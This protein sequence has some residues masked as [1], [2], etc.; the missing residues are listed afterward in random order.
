[1]QRLTQRPARSQPRPFTAYGV[2]VLTFGAALVAATAGLGQQPARAEAKATISVDPTSLGFTAEAFPRHDCHLDFGGGP[3]ADQDVWVFKLPGDETETGTFVNVTA[4]F[5]DP[6]GDTTTVVI[7]GEGGGTMVKAHTDKAWVA[8][9]QGLTLVGATAEVTGT[10]TSFIL[11]RTC[12]AGTEEPPPAG[13]PAPLP[14][15]SLSAPPVGAALPSPSASAS[16][17]GSASPSASASPS[18][19]ASPRPRPS[20]SASP[21]PSAP[22]LPSVA[23]SVSPS[24]APIVLPPVEPVPSASPPPP[25]PPGGHAHTASA[26]T[27]QAPEL[28]GL[29]ERILEIFH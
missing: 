6:D 7:P 24:T 4:E 20:R 18:G 27:Q 17:S 12:P 10:A 22:V 15:P 28:A 11:G 19:S 26:G 3:F 1:M 13:S 5:A 9:P 25:P 8:L 23:P 14:S 21:Q 29:W 2:A 16:P